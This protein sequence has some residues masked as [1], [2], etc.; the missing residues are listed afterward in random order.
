[1]G[2]QECL[3]HQNSANLRVFATQQQVGLNKN[4]SQED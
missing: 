4:M 1:M 3:E 2:Q